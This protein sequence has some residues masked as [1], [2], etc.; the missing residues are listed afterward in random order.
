MRGTGR[1][2]RFIRVCRLVW[3]PNDEFSCREISAEQPGGVDTQANVVAE[4]PDVCDD[5]RVGVSTRSRGTG[6]AGRPSF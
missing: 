3:L 6:G 5:G 1:C 4:R 2:A